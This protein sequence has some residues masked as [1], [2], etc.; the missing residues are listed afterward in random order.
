MSAQPEISAA[1]FVNPEQ[2]RREVFKAFDQYPWASD[3][4]F[5][6]GLQAVLSSLPS[7]PAPT[8]QPHVAESEIELRAK[9]FFYERKYGVKVDMVDFKA[10]KSA[11][12]SSA[13]GAGQTSTSEG[14]SKSVDQSVAAQEKEKDDAKADEEETPFPSSYAAI[15]ELILS[16]KP[17]PG[18][19]EIPD[20]VLGKEAES[21]SK[22]QQRRK[23][24]ETAAA[25]EPKEEDKVLE[26]AKEEVVEEKEEDKEK[27]EAS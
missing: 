14:K 12:S 7:S 25:S 16:G 23:P 1:G 2:T 26:E 10:W 22:A 27:E 15:V 13:S 17:V 18:I 21:E 8:S 11:E 4:D 9:S 20:T 6:T 19:M 5:Q 24:W 3:T